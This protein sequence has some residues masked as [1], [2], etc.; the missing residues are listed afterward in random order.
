MIYVFWLAIAFIIY[1]VVGYPTL[2]G[3]LSLLRSR[4]H[5][6]RE[7]FPAV[8]VITV[9]HNGAA[10]VAEKIRN[11]LAF[12]YPKEK[13]EIIVGSDGSTD[14][15]PEVVR[16]FASQG[17]KLVESLEWRGKHHVQML[18]RDIARGEI[19]VFTDA[20]IH[21]G[22]D[23]LRKMVAHFADS[24]IGCVCSVDQMQDTTGDW[25]GETLYVYGEMGLRRLEAKVSS[26]VSLSGSLFAVRRSMCDTWH[27]DQST[28]FFLALHAVARGMGAVLAP[29]CPARV[30][31]VRS[32]RGEFWRKVR[33]IVH[34]LVV[35]F[36]HLELL[37]PF[38]YG[39]F[40]WQLVSHKLCRWLLP[41]A[42]IATFFANFFLWRAGPFYQFC[43]VVQL[44]GCVMSSLSLLHGRLARISVIKL[45][46]FF[47][48]GNVA[49]LWAWWKFCLGEKYVTWEPSRRS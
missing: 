2:L 41:F 46:N 31:V 32:E 34:G 48:L 30:G 28:D 37:N 24:S 22:P 7:I 27:A 20:A 49:T 16:S 13:L 14:S 12:D 44:M 42:V 8:S 6:R 40:S 23:V 21:V 3:I 26:L 45:A 1:T 36:S 29:E 10:L 33:T 4:N 17:V 38:R 18:A 11:T 5:E 19:L 47:F 35:F 39:L 25:M 15:T 43:L 9:M